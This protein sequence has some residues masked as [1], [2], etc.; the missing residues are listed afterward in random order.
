ML[1]WPSW[2]PFRKYGA[3]VVSWRH[4]PSHVLPKPRCCVR[5][6]SRCAAF[7]VLFLLPRPVV[8]PPWGDGSVV[9]VLAGS[10]QEPPPRNVT[11][12]E[13]SHRGTRQRG[14][15]DVSVSAVYEKAKMSRLHVW[16]R[17][18]PLLFDKQCYAQLIRFRENLGKD[19][20]NRW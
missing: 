12:E 7:W 4:V 9:S 6:S 3:A 2:S 10:T 1:E 20:D 17:N 14:A 13:A 8:V 18:P 5:L 16:E 15:V 11:S 19:R